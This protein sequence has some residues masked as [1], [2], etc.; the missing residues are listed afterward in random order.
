MSDTKAV[1]MKAQLATY[2]KFNDIIDEDL[3]F[4]MTDLTLWTQ[5]NN[6]P[7][8]S[9]PIRS[10]LNQIATYTESVLEKICIFLM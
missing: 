8:I 5:D 6:L 1:E 7:K 9:V 2:L 4:V 10:S 3:L